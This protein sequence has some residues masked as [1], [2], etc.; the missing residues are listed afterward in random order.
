MSDLYIP[1][2]N[3][4]ATAYILRTII[5]QEIERTDESNL[6]NRIITRYY[7]AYDQLYRDK[8]LIITSDLWMKRMMLEIKQ[9]GK[10]NP[11][12]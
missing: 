1:E 10:I 3:I 12:Q 5:N 8:T 11:N 4:R 6:L 7:G 9:I 2:I